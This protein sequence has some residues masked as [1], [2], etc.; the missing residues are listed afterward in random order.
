VALLAGKSKNMEIRFPKLKQ[1]QK[2]ERGC[3][4]P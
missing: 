4:R 3:G 1:V 2:A